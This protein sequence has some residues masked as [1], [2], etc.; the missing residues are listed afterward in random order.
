MPHWSTILS[1]SAH[2]RSVP[3]STQTF[4][5]INKSSLGNSTVY[6]FMWH[7]GLSYIEING[8]IHY[9]YIYIYIVIHRHTVSL[10]HNSSVWLDKRDAS[11]WDW[12][13]AD[14]TSV[15]YLAAEL[16]LISAKVKEFLPIYIYILWHGIKYLSQDGS[17]FYARVMSGLSGTWPLTK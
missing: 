16:L 9:I 8:R 4:T 13:P 7:V 2:P 15:G 14:F 5:A 12:N 1:F 6:I 11:S 17:L 3:G 10:Y